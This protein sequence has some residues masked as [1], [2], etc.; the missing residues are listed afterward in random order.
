MDERV[1]E[2]GQALAEGRW[3]E[4]RDAFSAALAGAADDHPLVGVA[5]DGLG[6]ALW[7]LGEPHRAVEHRERAYGVFRRTG[8]RDR[9]ML[10]AMGVAIVYTSNF[11]N[12][13]VSGGWMRR[14]S[15]LLSGDDDPLAGWVWLIA[16]YVTTDLAQ[17]RELND[18][19][20]ARARRT[21]DL[22]LELCALSGLGKTLVS[23]GEVEAGLHLIDESMAGSLGGEYSRL[24]TVVYACCDML[25]ACDEAAD[26]TR[27]AQWCQVAHRFIARYGCPF[28]Y[29]RC[30]TIYGGLLVATG[31]WAGGER[32]LLAA[33]DMSAGAGARIAADVAARLADLRLRQGR[34]EEA[35]TLLREWQGEGRT[36][37]SVA[38]VRLARGDAAGA[39]A[40]LQR[41]LHDA[42]TG[43]V[44]T[45]A[46]LA[47]LVRARLAR[48]ELA[49]ATA[50][51]DVLSEL[52]GDGRAA[53]H[54]AGNGAL[55]A[56]NGA[57]TAGHGAPTAGHGALA[58]GNGALTAG[59]GTLTA[60][61]GALT[62]GD[63]ALTAGDG[64]LTAGNGALAS[65][66][67]ALSAGNGIGATAARGA[68]AAG[69][70]AF[71]NG[72]G[73]HG[74]G[75][76][77][78]GAIGRADVARV[79]VLG[80]G[81]GAPGHRTYAPAPGGNPRAAALAAV[82]AAQV[83]P[84]GQAAAHLE[85]ALHL[86][87]SLSL[88][89]E[90]ARTRLDLAGEYAGSRPEAA[91]AEAEAALV[92]FERL[93]A[94]ADADAAAAQLRRLG[95]TPRTSRRTAGA[96]TERERQ[97]LSLVAKG[98]SNSEIGARLHI[99]RKTAAHHVSNVL[100]KVGARNRAEAVAR[101][102]DP[103]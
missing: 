73:P 75:A 22:D 53:T 98:L 51:A 78:I 2:G 79:A 3:A 92:A 15:R 4:A 47:L 64:A 89:Y 74:N 96:L 49:E 56:G 31:D 1:A 68:G 6:E 83:R 40:V 100:A 102:V 88:P 55:T 23:S 29:A 9:A 77:G 70:G 62:A 48:G 101:T 91:V 60:G 38:A 42:M 82:A 95:V 14:T 12:R 87:G 26:L 35:E 50:A 103:A 84:G 46:G 19:A 80:N 67:G 37:V 43:P 30:R 52:A 90:A 13:A 58:S 85:R 54:A 66:N 28:L 5:L 16:A 69:N 10:A 99:S 71:G 41:R 94:V 86:F 93:G 17:A 57:L 20:L 11:D 72:T 39:V 27:A 18:R 21:G 45:A 63:G 24:D 44:E 25:E 65:G 97:V 7:W 76:A 61:D 36:A 81:V 59:N 33:M 8:D 34:L 32:E